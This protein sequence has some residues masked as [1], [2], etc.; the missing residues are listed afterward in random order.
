MAGEAAALHQ[1]IFAAE[2]LEPGIA[3]VR[4]F[5]SREGLSM[6][7]EVDVDVEIATTSVDPRAWLLRRAFLAVGEVHGRAVLRRW[8]GVV[9]RVRERVS[10]GLR[11]RITVTIGSPLAPLTLLTDMRIFQEKPAKAIVEELLK[12][13]GVDMSRVAW[14]LEGSHPE[15]EVC[16]QLGETSL[17]FMNRILEEDGIFYFFE[18]ADDGTTI[19]FADGPSAYAE[20]SPSAALS[21][22]EDAGLVSREAISEIHEWERVR[23]GKVT[24]RDHDFQRPSLDLEARAEGDAPLGIEHYDYPGRYVDPSE[25]KRRAQ[26]RLDAFTS[27]HRVVR[28]EG[29]AFSLVPGHTFTL[30]DAPDTA[31]DQEWVVRSLE[32]SWS[33]SEAEGG[34]VVESRFEL[35]PK[36]QPFRPPQRAPR[37]A[38]PG[39]QIATVTGPEGAEIHTDDHG[40]VKV[41][42][43]WDRRSTRDDK[44]SCWVRVGQMHS[45][46]AV[47]IP[48]VGWEVVVDFEGGDPDRPVIVGRLY[49]GKF[50]P[51]YPLPGAKTKSS[52][53]SSSSPGGGGHNEIRMEDGG[54]GEQVHMHAEKDLTI[55]VANNKTEKVATNSTSAVGTNHTLT[56]GSNETLSVGA[57]YELTIGGSQT[58]AVGASRTKSVS[59]AENVT[60]HGSRTLSIGGS[61]TTTSSKSVE[62]STP[63]ALDETVGG[64]CIEAAALGVSMA[65]AGSCNISVGGAKIDAVATG[66][67]DFTLGA[68]ATTVGGAFVS[69]SGADVGTNTSGAKVTTVGGAWA[70]NAGGDFEL[71]SDANVSINVGGA[72]AFNASE[73]VFE[74]GGS[75]VT[76]SGGSVSIKSSEIK[77]TATGPQ[78]ELAPGVEDC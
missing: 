66:K 19:V 2:G 18:H 42:F 3:Q 15:R 63:A 44:S 22:R 39:A 8:G 13:A 73:I 35:L 46:G 6:S 53:Q 29:P 65:V 7:Y 9:T 55:N 56:V 61:H 76:I 16:T 5:A 54:G 21:F 52:L 47:A 41:H 26:L 72:V 38:F 62:T 51:P 4:R 43:P 45:S 20:T 14:R 49:N 27:E 67:T 69:A 48:R 40:R 50:G 17:T 30:E 28:G 74:V 36:D 78:P 1:M 10:R 33:E 12:D 24:L 25:G 57:A 34:A 11:H 75:N 32:Q 31:L 37:A 59:A 68:M 60:I 58:W 64:S 70:V 77:L 23:P 71:S